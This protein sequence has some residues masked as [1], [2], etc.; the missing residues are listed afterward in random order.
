MRNL[1]YVSALVAL[2]GCLSQTKFEEKF[3]DKY[4]EEYLACTTAEGATCGEGTGTTDAEPVACEFD[5]AAAKACL[6]GTY[7]CNDEFPGVEFV[8]IPAECANVCGSVADTDA[9]ADTD[10]AM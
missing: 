9:P 10:V 7:S 4:C 1:L 3:A 8:V 5:K 2:G 6:D